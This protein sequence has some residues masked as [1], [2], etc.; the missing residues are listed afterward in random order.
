MGNALAGAGSFGAPELEG[1]RQTTRLRILGPAKGLAL[2][3]PNLGHSEEV[4]L[5]GLVAQKVALSI[6]DL[7]DLLRVVETRA[8]RGLR[9]VSV[10]SIE[11]THITPRTSLSALYRRHTKYS[12]VAA[13]AN[14]HLSTP[15]WGSPSEGN[16]MTPPRQG[17]IMSSDQKSVHKAEYQ[18][19]LKRL[20]QARAD[21]GLTQTQVAKALRRPQTFVSKAELGE[22]RLDVLE[23]QEFG[24]VYGKP[25]S[26]FFP[27]A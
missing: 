21:A 1:P 19:F 25:F 18:R 9:L 16:T 17:G 11:E 26:Y 7:D 24:K 22:R 23:V 4:G 10:L 8:L 27:S 3:A 20:R 12:Q 6:A 15:F 2:S 14:P 13:P 5:L